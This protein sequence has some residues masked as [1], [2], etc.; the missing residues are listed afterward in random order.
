MSLTM[1]ERRLLL[2]LTRCVA[3]LAA[4][5]RVRAWAEDRIDDE[6][7]AATIQEN[8][9]VIQRMLIGITPAVKEDEG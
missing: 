3:G 7:D 2:E 5:V 9:G 6:R 8:L 4:H 1:D